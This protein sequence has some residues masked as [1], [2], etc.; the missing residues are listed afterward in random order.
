MTPV[1]HQN[2]KLSLVVWLRCWPVEGQWTNGSIS[3]LDGMVA[4]I[5]STA[6]L[7]GSKGV[8]EAISRSNRALCHSIHSVHVHRKP[9]PNT[10]PMNAGAVVFEFVFD[11]DRNV[12]IGLLARLN[13]TN[14]N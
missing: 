6:I 10:V 8:V 1:S 2:W 9:L 11:D 14:G 12:L 5:P 4:V 3:I 13:R 7:H